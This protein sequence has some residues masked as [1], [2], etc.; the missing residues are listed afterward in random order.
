M[1]APQRF[2]TSF[3]VH[4]SVREYFT[5]LQARLRGRHWWESARSE[6][7]SDRFQREGSTRIDL[8]HRQISAILIGHGL[9]YL[10]NY[11]PL[12]DPDPALIDAVAAYLRNHP[13]VLELMERDVFR[14]IEA[15]PKVADPEAVLVSPPAAEELPRL[16]GK[17]DRSG[18]LTGVDFLAREQRNRSLVKAG[19]QFVLAFETARL[20][21][22]GLDAY[23]SAVEHVVAEEG[24]GA[25][26]AIHSYGLDGSDR[27]IEVKT[28]AYGRETPFYV[29]APEVAMS[30]LHG[31]RFW[32]YRVFAFRDEPRLYMLHGAL[33]DSLNL[34][35]TE[36]RASPK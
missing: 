17:L 16:D 19:Q 14:P 1:K 35:P 2:T 3:S 6:T 15:I 34:E 28:T 5:L 8:Q 31:D 25:G 23:A 9:P 30:R 10:S 29:S 22:R 33:D 18:P 27:Y 7:V 36:Y 11:R 13:A 21:A 32:I 24:D 4:A 20:L 12:P 26:Y